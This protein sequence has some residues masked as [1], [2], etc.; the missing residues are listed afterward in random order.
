LGKS[1]SFKR[2]VACG[3]AW[4]GSEKTQAP[5]GW[6]RRGF[7]E[8]VVVQVAP[9]ARHVGGTLERGEGL[10]AQAQQEFIVLV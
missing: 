1:I 8:S 10:E 3:V 6:H 4:L 2:T 9:K 5:H 7:L